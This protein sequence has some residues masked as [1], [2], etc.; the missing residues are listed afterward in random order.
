[1]P[2]SECFEPD[3][4]APD[5]S[6]GFLGLASSSNSCPS[7]PSLSVW[8]ES[9]LITL[10]LVE[11]EGGGKESPLPPDLEDGGGSLDVSPVLGGGRSEVSLDEDGT[12]FW[13]VVGKAVLV[14]AAIGGDGTSSSS[15]SLP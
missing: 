15:E 3:P 12:A 13:D 8:R 1:M 11:L 10:R 4:A 2:N 7:S 5:P 9:T 14:E 6:F